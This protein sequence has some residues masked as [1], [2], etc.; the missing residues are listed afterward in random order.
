MSDSIGK[1]EKWGVDRNICEQEP[2]VMGF[3]KNIVEELGE[4]IEAE[5][6]QDTQE[7]VDAIGDILVFGITELV[8]YK[9]NTDHVLYEIHKE[10]TSRTGEWSEDQ[11]KWVKYKTPEAKALWYKAKFRIGE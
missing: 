3:V 10:L 9:T 4:L 8:K 6:N 5:K 1:I 7:Q 2:I 11:N